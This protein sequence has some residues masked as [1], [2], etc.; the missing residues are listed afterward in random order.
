MPYKDAKIYCDGSHYIAIPKIT[1]PKRPK[2]PEKKLAKS[3][4][5]I[6]DESV[7]FSNQQITNRI[8]LKEEFESK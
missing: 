4:Q 7:S 5:I 1:R 2:K 3:N 6:S 8:N